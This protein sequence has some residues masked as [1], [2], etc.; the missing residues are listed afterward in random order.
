MGSPSTSPSEPSEE[1]TG[2]SEEEETGSSEEEETSSSEEEVSPVEPTEAPVEP[3]K[4]PTDA[5]PCSICGEGQVVTNPDGMVDLGEVKIKC[6]D[7][8]DHGQ[9]GSIPAELCESI[10]VAECSCESTDVEPT[11]APVEPTEAPV[12]PTEAPVEP[13]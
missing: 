9:V 7:L 11:E 4:E 5:P 3:T 6:S 12:E 2:S 10:D 1:E 13:T 8:Q